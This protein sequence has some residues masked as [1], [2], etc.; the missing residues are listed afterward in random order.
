MMRRADHPLLTHVLLLLWIAF[1]GQRWPLC[2]GVVKTNH[3]LLRFCSPVFGAPAWAVHQQQ[4]S[5]WLGP[6]VPAAPSEGTQVL[7]LCRTVACLQLRGLTRQVKLSVEVGQCWAQEATA[8]KWMCSAARPGCFC[9]C[10]AVK[11]AWVQFME[12]LVVSQLV[13]EVCFP[14]P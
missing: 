12:S 10:R 8:I 1:D 7:E 13:Q 5:S 11:G 2:S 6:R 4:A 9:H 3:R 14:A